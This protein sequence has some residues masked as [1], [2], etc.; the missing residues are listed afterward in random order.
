MKLLEWITGRELTKRNLENMDI[1]EQDDKVIIPKW[2]FVI[3]VHAFYE[4]RRTNSIYAIMVLA[5]VVAMVYFS[6]W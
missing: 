2:Q 4:Y 6:I 3:F 5:L 1:E